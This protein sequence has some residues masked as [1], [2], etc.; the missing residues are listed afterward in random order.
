MTRFRKLLLTASVVLALLIP[1]GTIAS[2]DP[3]GNRPSSGYTTT[4]AS[5]PSDG[6]TI[7]P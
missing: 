2:A 6:G 5:D 3:G 4:T 7:G 1:L